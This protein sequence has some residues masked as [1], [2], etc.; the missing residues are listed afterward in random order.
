MNTIN[1]IIVSIV[2]FIFICLFVFF[3]GYYYGS[4]T[5]EPGI[6]YKDK[7]VTNTIFRDRALT[8]DEC[9]GHLNKYDQGEFILDIEHRQ[10]NQ[11]TIYGELHERKASRDVEIELARSGSWK[12][13]IAG[14]LIAGAVLSYM[15]LK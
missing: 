11:Y 1:K 7:I 12:F 6:I 2:G 5:V 13:Y 10:N 9:K 15:V 4:R 14:G 8:L 3:S